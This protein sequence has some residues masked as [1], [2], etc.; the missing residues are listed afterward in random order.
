MPVL[1]LKYGTSNV[2]AVC[3]SDDG[4]VSKYFLGYGYAKDLYAHF[5]SEHDFYSDLVEHIITKLELPKGNLPIIAAG[6]PTVPAIGRN[7]VSSA[8]LD[9]L[10]SSVE[11]YEVVCFANGAVFTQNN[12]LSYY[13]SEKIRFGNMETNYLLNLAVYTNAF[14]TRP[15]DYNLV[16]A[17]IWGMLNNNRKGT[18]KLILNS[19]PILFFGDILNKALI[20]PEF[21]K[22]AYLYFLSMVVNPG[23]YTIKVDNENLVP[24]FLHLRKFNIDLS[25][26]YD[27]FEPEMLCTL[28]NSPGETS[29]LVS[30]EMGTSQLMDIKPGRIFFVPVDKNA[31]ARLVIKS[32]ELGSI[33]KTVQGGKLGVVIDT[34]AKNDIA[35][36]DYS[37][38]QMDIN[39]NLKNISEVL[40]RL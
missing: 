4:K 10:L 8:T 14:P 34:R 36:Y 27:E 19:K 32:Q 23:I 22:I 6:F 37:S 30:T 33:E 17:S 29:C 2:N 15:S 3:L 24:H 39:S 40:V 11:N 5:Y 1:S 12:H 35:S 31:S 21:E 28:V 7:Y 16:L 26:Y 38:L 9:Q 20:N 18:N 13:D 25:S